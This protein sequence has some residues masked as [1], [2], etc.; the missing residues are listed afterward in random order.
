MRLLWL[1]FESP[2]HPDAVCHPATPDEV[3][4]VLELLASPSSERRRWAEQLRNYFAQQA[5]LAPW[6][7]PAVPCRR[8][9][10][11]YVLVPWRLAQW[12][13]AVLPAA[14]GL[15]ERTSQR[16]VR[17]LAHGD[18]RVVNATS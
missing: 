6:S 15:L 11:L 14:D 18:T 5:S 13:A 2:P 12:L 7:R 8:A 1:A 16:L 4:L 9:S 3:H 10:G 17:W